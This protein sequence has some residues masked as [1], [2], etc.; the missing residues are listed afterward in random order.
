M[1]VKPSNVVST[2]LVLISFTLLGQA[3]AA[4]VGE[5]GEMW[6][7]WG[8]T[9]RNAY[10][11]AY[12]KGI[13]HGYSSGCGSGMDY[14]SSKRRYDAKEAEEY[15]SGCISRSPVTLKGIDDKAIIH[16]TTEFY[17]TYPK[18]RFLYISDV[19]LKLLAGHT[20]EQI[21]KEFQQG[22]EGDAK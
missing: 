2:A 21:H 16:S 18:Q 14:L 1:Q 5:E 3:R 15:L 4:R 10:V 17:R 9:T 11:F 20:L 12:V 19:L 8:A 6:L 22:D 13:T 7:R